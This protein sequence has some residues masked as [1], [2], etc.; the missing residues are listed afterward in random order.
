MR[1]FV[2]GKDARALSFRACTA[3]AGGYI[4]TNYF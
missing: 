4:S 3:A 2:F 1:K